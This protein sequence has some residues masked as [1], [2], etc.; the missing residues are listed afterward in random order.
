MSTRIVDA[1][2]E[3][4]ADLVAFDLDGEAGDREAVCVIGIEARADVEGPA[5]SAAGDDAAVELALGERVAGV[6]TGVLHGI[7]GFADA[8]QADP[9][10]LENH[11]Q[12]AVGRNVLAAGNGHERQNGAHSMLV[13]SSE[14]ERR[15]MP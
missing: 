6:R 12:S 9:D 8:I 2:R 1:V 7:D 3:V 15:R 11:V 4:D 14:E 5:M 10:A 13:L